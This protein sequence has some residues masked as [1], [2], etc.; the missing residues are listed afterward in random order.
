MSG[1]LAAH[2][3]SGAPRLEEIPGFDHP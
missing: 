1:R 3:L 2:A